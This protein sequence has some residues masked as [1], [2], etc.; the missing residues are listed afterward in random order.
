MTNEPRAAVELDLPKLPLA[1]VASTRDKLVPRGIGWRVAVLGL[2]IIYVGMAVAVLVDATTPSGY[3]G[4]HLDPGQPWIYPSEDVQFSLT[5]MTIEFVITSLTLVVRTRTTIWTRAV[6]LA[7]LHFCGMCGFGVL[8]MHATRPFLDHIV[9]LFF[10]CGFLVVF[11]I[12]S[13]IAHAVVRRRRLV[14]ARL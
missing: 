7:F 6:M 8:A 4:A 2:L 13:G 5:A 3:K 1:V 9:Y 11:A 14:S 12:G 10:A